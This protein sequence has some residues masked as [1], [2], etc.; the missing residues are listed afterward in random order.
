MVNW[1]WWDA[2]VVDVPMASNL[3]FVMLSSVECLC[4]KSHSHAL[5]FADYA[6]ASAPGIQDERPDHIR[7]GKR[8]VS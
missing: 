8:D 4:Y 2:R 1:R 7:E 6:G 3:A 5:R